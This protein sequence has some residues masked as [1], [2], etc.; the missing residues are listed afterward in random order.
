MIRRLLKI[1]AFFVLGGGLL[2]ICAYTA[3]LIAGYN[4]PR[5]W[6]LLFNR[7][8]NA[9]WLYASNDVE[10]SSEWQTRF[11]IYWTADNIE[12]VER[13]FRNT[14]RTTSLRINAFCELESTP[15]IDIG[16]IKL[17]LISADQSAQNILCLMSVRSGLARFEQALQ[18]APQ[19]GTLLIY[20]FNIWV[21]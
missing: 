15:Q 11:T 19:T 2:C 8:P 20:E 12:Q 4:I 18:Q 9:T 16:E 1:A 3:L 7:Y 10:G 17:I 5:E 13:H 21:Y 6:N 14:G